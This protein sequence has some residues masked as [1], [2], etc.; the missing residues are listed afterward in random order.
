MQFIFFAMFRKQIRSRKVHP[1]QTDYLSR[2]FV[3]QHQKK[4]EMNS[5]RHH[6]PLRTPAILA[7]MR[8]FLLDNDKPPS[9][10][11]NP[12]Q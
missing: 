5:E 2:P 11:A 1:M 7:M 9:N 10:E 3:T 8:Q 4:P 6:Y 12:S